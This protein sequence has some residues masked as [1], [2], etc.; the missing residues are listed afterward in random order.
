MFK[1]LF[2]LFLTV[3]LVEIYLLI[4]IGAHIGALYTVS[5]CILTALLGAL[6]LR[7]QGFL[8]LARAQR[9]L[10]QGK[11]PADHLLEG[12]I[13]LLAG[14]LLLTPGFATD[15]LGFLCL[16]SS[17]R[18]R[19]A[20]ALLQRLLRSRRAAGRDRGVVIDGESWREDHRRL[21]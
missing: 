1:I 10:A 21:P 12:V 9:K 4:Q 18:A 20:Q 16:V 14:V 2:L 17:L 6:L 11:L 8:T 13:L 3:P 19:L 7:I 15:V 5:L